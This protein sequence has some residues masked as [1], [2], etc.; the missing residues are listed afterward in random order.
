M[1]AFRS[2]TIPKNNL[3]SWL[4]IFCIPTVLR[5]VIV[6]LRI[7]AGST[8]VLIGL[9]EKFLCQRLT[10][11]LNGTPRNK[12]RTPCD[13]FL[14]TVKVSDLG[15][16]SLIFCV[17]I[18]ASICSVIVKLVVGFLFEVTN[19]IKGNLLNLVN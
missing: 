12:Y 11:Y 5:L 15:E 7:T 19:F 13:A 9:T 8:V 16:V 14:G 2:L 4:R 1:R 17:V 18:I 6:H 10:E 3:I